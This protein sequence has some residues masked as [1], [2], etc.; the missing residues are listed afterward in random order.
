MP[1]IRNKVLKRTRKRCSEKKGL[2]NC[3]IGANN[4]KIPH[5][6]KNIVIN[7]NKNYIYNSEKIKY[8]KG[9]LAI[10]GQY[11]IKG[12]NQLNKN[13]NVINTI[14]IVLI[15]NIFLI[16]NLQ[17][18]DI[19]LSIRKDNK[20]ILD[21]FDNYRDNQNTNIF[22]EKEIIKYQNNDTNFNITYKIISTIISALIIIIFNMIIILLKNKKVI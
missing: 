18:S 12:E 5:R 13:R 3:F 10:K 6:E 1:K 15:L 2:E 11:I 21:N 4:K 7:N 20:N 16:Y 19:F 22:N 14:I 9:N 17:G 8:L